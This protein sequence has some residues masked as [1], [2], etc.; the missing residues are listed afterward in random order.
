M[1]SGPRYWSSTMRPRAASSP[2]VERRRR[3]P[4]S[5]RTSATASGRTWRETGAPAGKGKGGVRTAKRAVCTSRAPGR[6]RTTRAGKTLRIPVRRAT[7][8]VAGRVS[9][10][11]GVPAWTISPPARTAMRSPRAQ[12]SPRSWVTRMTAKPKRWRSVC[13]S[14]RRTRRSGASRAAKGSSSSSAAGSVARARA[15]ATR[16]CC[17]PRAGRGG[18]PPGRPARAGRA[19]R[20]PAGGAPAGAAHAGRRPRCRPP[21]GGGRGRSSGARSP[22]GGAAAGPPGPARCPAA[23]RRPG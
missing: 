11:S 21:S 19:A 22:A 5:S 18:A 12:A 6:T 7:R 13:S 10:S 2:P 15:S 9:T 1:C 16:C 20:R 4:V 17:P 23:P 14:R 8:G 3:A